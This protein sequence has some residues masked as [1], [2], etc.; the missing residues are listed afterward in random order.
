MK[1]TL[2]FNLPEEKE[3]FKHAN[4]GVVYFCQLEEMQLFLRQLYKY[5][6][7]SDEKSEFL[8]EIRD[9]FYEIRENK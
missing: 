1:A 2:E 7:I 9:K 8:D 5:R 4:N 6:E 3:E